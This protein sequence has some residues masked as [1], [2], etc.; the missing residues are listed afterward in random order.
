MKLPT[1]RPLQSSWLGVITKQDAELA[2]VGDGC[3]SLSIVKVPKYGDDDEAEA[4]TLNK[5]LINGTRSLR[6]MRSK[7]DDALD[8]KRKMKYSS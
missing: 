2:S 5:F 1:S 6:L 3:S 7:I 4:A 8:Q